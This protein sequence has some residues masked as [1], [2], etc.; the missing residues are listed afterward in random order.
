HAVQLENLHQATSNLQMLLA[1]DVPVIPAQDTLVSLVAPVD[2]TGLDHAAI[3]VLQQQLES[4]EAEAALERSLL[5]PEVSVGYFLQNITESDV[6]FRGL[7]GFTF[8]VAIPLWFRPQQA[9]IQRS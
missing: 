1:S 5:F 8:E 4:K 2:T 7:Q 9:H 3:R 6:R